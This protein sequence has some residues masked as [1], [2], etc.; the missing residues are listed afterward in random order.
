MLKQISEHR[1][2]REKKGCSRVLNINKIQERYSSTVNMRIRGLK[3]K[4]SVIRSSKDV[5]DN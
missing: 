2:A 5:R 3:I 1:K 4:E